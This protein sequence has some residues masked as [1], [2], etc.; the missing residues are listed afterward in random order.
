[1]KKL[2]IAVPFVLAACNS[3]N[4]VPNVT[5]SSAQGAGFSPYY[6]GE[7]NARLANEEPGLINYQE[8]IGGGK[9]SYADAVGKVKRG[10]SSDP[11]VAAIE[12]AVYSGRSSVGVGQVQLGDELLNVERRAIEGDDFA[13]FS[14]VDGQWG[15][16]FRTSGALRDKLPAITG[17]AWGG[18]SVGFGQSS[19]RPAKVAMKLS[20]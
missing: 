16:A 12:T 14:P 18:E 7:Y 2:L 1:M 6:L 3:N 5:L 9:Q 13:V 20:C 15:S 19:E 4:L 11:R 8:P 17:C 10:D